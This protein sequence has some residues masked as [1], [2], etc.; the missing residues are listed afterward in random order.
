M[1]HLKIAGLACLMAT[2]T[3]V[4]ISCGKEV[5]GPTGAQG[6]QGP[7]GPQG[8]AG[9][10][11]ATGSANVIY[12]SWIKAETSDWKEGNS[13]P[14]EAHIFTIDAPKITADVLDKGVLLLYGQFDFMAP[15]TYQLPLR[16][17]LKGDPGDDYVTNV[18]EGVVRIL[19]IHSGSEMTYSFPQ[20]FRYIIIPGSIPSERIANAKKMSY[21]E[22]C[23]TYHIKP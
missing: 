17:Y 8:P 19:A 15:G 4:S 9:S 12:S 10:E 2:I 3:L 14:W 21:E 13:G 22:V 18:A 1:K 6:T 7:A 23:K 5:P 20:R 16:T 11:G